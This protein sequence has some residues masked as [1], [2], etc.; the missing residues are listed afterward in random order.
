MKGK[1]TLAKSKPGPPT[2]QYL[3]IAEI[4]EDVVILKDGT[5]RTVL[6]VSSINFALKS[7]DE[8]QATI[9]SYMQF[10]NGLEY[11]VQIVVQSRKMNIDA[12]LTALDDQEK[13]ISNELLRAQIRDYRSFVND[14]VELGEIMQ[15]RFYLVIPYDPSSDKQRNF[16]TKLQEAISPAKIIKLKTEQF[17]ERK[18]AMMQRVNVLSGA[19]GSMGLQSAMLD[20]QGLI[21]LYYTVYNPQVFDRQKMQ[22][23]SKVRL[24]E[25]F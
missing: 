7:Q 21:E 2:Q 22:D 3:D 10:L 20:T 5:L 15:K 9:Q 18:Q 13:K 24:E 17:A 6:M 11:P 23:T 12:Y 1:N 4:R 16:W 25:G 8:Q 14:L 19:L